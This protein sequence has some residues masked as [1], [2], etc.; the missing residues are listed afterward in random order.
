VPAGGLRTPETIAARLQSVT[1]ATP[2]LV[3]TAVPDGWS[4][5]VSTSTDGFGIHYTGPSFEDVRL[6]I[7]IPNPR[8]PQETGTQEF[9]FRS[10]PRALYQQQDASDPLTQRFLIWNEPGD[11]A[12]SATAGG[13]GTVGV[14]Y[15]LSATRVTEAV[16][17]QIADTLTALP[18][19][20]RPTTPE[21]VVDPDHGLHDSQRVRVVF[22]AFGPT[23]RVRLSQC[24]SAAAASAPGCGDLP[25][26]QPFADMDANGNGST[27][28]VVHDHASTAPGDTMN[29]VTCRDQCVLVASTDTAEGT[30]TTAP[31][32]FG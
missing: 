25:Q 14:P 11:W 6:S 4:A 13:A 29:T 9:G 5:E 16:F 8:P 21:L 26:S 20:A 2:L 17:W 32:G 28:F 1:G 30:P 7:S 31:L 18:L 24:A 19:P 27:M 15:F 12:R 22:I 10:D 3:P 23:S